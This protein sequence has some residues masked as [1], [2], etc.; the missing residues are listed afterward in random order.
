MRHPL[1][2]YTGSCPDLLAQQLAESIERTSAFDPMMPLWIGVGQRGMERTVRES[3]AQALGIA[4]NIRLAF[5]TKLV[6]NAARALIHGEPLTDLDRQSRVWD[7]G[8]L[9]WAIY[10]ELRAAGVDG[11]LR[12]DVYD[13]LRRWLHQAQGG[14]SAPSRRV[15][16]ELCE[17]LARVFDTYTLDRPQ[18]HEFWVYN[19]SESAFGPSTMRTENEAPS[20]LRWQP[21]LWRRVHARLGN[22]VASPVELLRAISSAS[23]AQRDAFRREM[24]ALHLF[25]VVH[26]APR[27]VALIQELRTIIPVN[28]YTPSPT[29]AWWS[30]VRAS[31]AEASGV[32]PLLTKFGGHAKFLHDVIIELADGGEIKDLHNVP[33]NDS[34]LH[35]VQ[36]AVLMPDER[37][38]QPYTPR[39]DDCSIAFHR[40][41]GPLRQVEVLHDL[42]LDYIANDPT[43]EPADFTVLCPKLDVF[44]P[45]IEAVFKSQF[46]RIPLRIEDASLASTNQVA[47]AA[48][49]L[50]ELV[51]K[52]P[53][54]LD[55]L[56]LLTNDTI[57]AR[58]E[59]EEDH[60]ETLT[61]WMKDLDVRWGWNVDARAAAGRPGD[62]V[63]SWEHALR[64]LA[65]GVLMSSE[66]DGAP[67]IVQG[68]IP[69][70]AVATGDVALA[71]RF[72]R[73][74]REVFAFIDAFE[75]D[76][77]IAGWSTWLIGEAALNRADGT[78]GASTANAVLRDDQRGA[79]ARMVKTDA[80]AAFTMDAVYQKIAE[81]PRLAA[82]TGMLDDTIDADAFRA[83]V[84]RQLQSDATRI[85]SSS[86][87][88][89]FARL[90]ASRFASAKVTILLG[91]DDGSFPRPA[92]LPSWDLRQHFPQKNDRSDRLEDIYSILQAFLTT[93]HS[94]AVI[95]QGTDP[96]TNASVP[97]ALPILEFERL[98]GE[99]LVDG[100]TELARRT[101]QHRLQPFAL[102]TFLP[103]EGALNRPF[104][105]Q[106][107]WAQAAYKAA[108]FQGSRGH[109]PLVPD[110]FT[111]D[112]KQPPHE[113]DISTFARVLGRPQQAFLQ[114][115]HA[116]ALEPFEV[117]LHRDDPGAHNHLDAYQFTQQSHA[118]RVQQQRNGRSAEFDLESDDALVLRSRAVVRPGKLGLAIAE[119]ALTGIPEELF[120]I[121]D[122]VTRDIDPVL[123][124]ATV[125][126][127][128]LFARVDRVYVND[129]GNVLGPV[130]ETPSK[131]Y[132]DVMFQA[133]ALTALWA[134]HHGQSASGLSVHL[135]TNGALFDLHIPLAQAQTWLAN[136]VQRVGR[137]WQAPDGF[138]RTCLRSVPYNP[139]KQGYD[140]LDFLTETPESFWPSSANLTEEQEA[141]ERKKFADSQATFFN[142][143]NTKW[144]ANAQQGG[145]D[146]WE[147][148]ILGKD[149]EWRRRPVS[150]DIFAALVPED[151]MHEPSRK[152]SVPDGAPSDE[153]DAFDRQ[154]VDGA[155]TVA[156]PV[157][158]AMFQLFP[159][160]MESV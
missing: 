76:Q 43:L 147:T 109:R 123:L 1:H 137:S 74:V 36:R 80:G 125:E 73:F 59:I 140:K 66:H 41:H 13:P 69:Y 2:V 143:L 119:R 160:F 3:I 157:A 127:M 131:P 44:A 146:V 64:R 78:G 85:L 149:R 115:A 30:D 93:S 156:A 54:P 75:G 26:F 6:Q 155:R 107:A 12:Q 158:E 34:I 113:M 52:R 65:L 72:V 138:N 5:P 135:R 91:M 56:E 48:V 42:I 49:Q 134:L 29:S 50:L 159:P 144:R 55:M 57:R 122:P 84:V 58:F 94:F 17:Q 60:L 10:A 92:Q 77:S 79:L 114:R 51:D 21:D 38:L 70:G 83:W 133:Y 128:T 4:A 132:L 33:G 45:V 154:L 103:R 117:E 152:R 104:T 97:P 35:H 68:H 112:S 39:P 46:P 139:E 116:V 63:S 7:A 22:A 95:W 129:K 102:S 25:G 121:L 99:H 141:K 105:Y 130:F 11:P 14:E 31:E 20:D 81:L 71:G 124:R 27:Q 100:D 118:V 89:S 87:A 150:A 24:P 28:I 151:A 23:D 145:P 110:G 61:R 98:L 53:S 96:S 62:T 82:T 88:V 106:R 37:T 16:T 142:A 32:S 153:P 108:L 8:S 67:S 47:K 18:W 120:D 148:A 19:Q 15:L 136:G 111:D 9:Q 90:T 40:S 126:G 86:N 101:T